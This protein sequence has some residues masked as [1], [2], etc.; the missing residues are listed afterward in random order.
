MINQLYSKGKDIYSIDMVHVYINE[1]KPIQI[2]MPFKSLEQALDQN[3]WGTSPNTVLSQPDKYPEMYQR[4]NAADLRY[5]I[6]LAKIRKAVH[7]VDGFHRL[8]KAKLVGRTTIKCY[9]IDND[10]FKLF[11]I[12]PKLVQTMTVRDMIE[13]YK[14]RFTA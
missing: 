7:L 10:T 4:I 3:I 8:A 13:L 12:P 11:K 1:T 14:K 2:N 6:I 9:V 5:P